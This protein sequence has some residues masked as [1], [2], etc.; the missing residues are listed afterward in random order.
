MRERGNINIV[1]LLFEM[2]ALLYNTSSL[3]SV[4]Y[5]L[6][7]GGTALII[8][9]WTKQTTVKIKRAVFIGFLILVPIYMY[10]MVVHFSSASLS[11]L[12]SLLISAVLIMC[13]S[14]LDLGEINEKIHRWFMLGQILIIIIPKILHTGINPFD[15]GYMSI[16]STTT[17]LGIF[18]CMS[19]EICIIF[20]IISKKK[21]WLFYI[22]PWMYFIYLSK[23]RTAFIGVVFFSLLIFGIHFFHNSKSKR[24]LLRGAKWGIFILLIIVII[25]YPQLDQFS[26]YT[27]LSSAVYIYTGKILMSGRNV[28]WKNALL[29]INNKPILGYGLDYSQYFDLPVHNSYLNILLQT[30]FVG[31]GCVMLMINA[32]LN[33]IVKGNSKLSHIIYIFCIVNLFMCSTE[34]MLLQGQVILQIIMWTL[35]GVGMNKKYCDQ[36]K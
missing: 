28:I 31:L 19:I 11:N 18:S 16:F 15:G 9:F 20:F 34:V 23:V 8:L 2:A 21:A 13:F 3:Q 6:I 10:S 17:F 22:I 5:I 32:I 36:F 25:I 7:L 27:K 29:I 35:L 14:S 4:G 12:F 24:S 1:L 33:K 30:G 26:W